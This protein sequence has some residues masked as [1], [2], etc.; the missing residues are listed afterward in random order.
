MVAMK[1]LAHIIF[2]SATLCALVSCVH[3]ATTVE[4]YLFNPVTDQVVIRYP[5]SKPADIVSLKPSLNLVGKDFHD[6]EGQLSYTI[7]EKG[8]NLFTGTVAVRIKNSHFNLQID[9][10]RKF[11]TADGIHWRIVCNGAEAASGHSDLAWARFHGKVAYKSG[12][13]RSTSIVL[14]PVRFNGFGKIEIPVADDGIFDAM[15]PAR[16]YSIVNVNGGGYRFDAM[17]RWAGTYDLTHDREDRFDVGRTEIYGLRAFEIVGGPRS[18]FLFFRP[19]S[20]TRAMHFDADGDGLLSDAEMNSMLQGLKSSPTAIGPELN[21][22][23]VKVWFDNMPLQV[24]QLNQIPEFDGD[25]MWQVNY[26]V[27]CPLPAD[28]KISQNVW[29][30]IKIEVESVETLRGKSISDFGQGSVDM[31]WTQ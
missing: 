25:G 8:R 27:Q 19:S 20:L 12:I 17:E 7:E 2:L 6:G 10:E 14:L 3:A 30:H 21:A 28:Q 11:S 31:M 13:P 22:N 29:H 5:Y 4:A 1:T 26:I 24:A 15:V 23:S 9:L 18:I 16:V